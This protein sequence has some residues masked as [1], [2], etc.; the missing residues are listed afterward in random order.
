MSNQHLQV[1][2]PTITS[3]FEAFL[4]G[5]EVSTENHFV[6]IHQEL[7]VGVYHDS[8]GYQL[9]TICEIL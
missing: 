9:L 8:K 3:N 5:L 1:H 7:V 2:T 4:W 6:C